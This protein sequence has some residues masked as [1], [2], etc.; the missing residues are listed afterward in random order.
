MQNM[1]TIRPTQAH[2]AKRLFELVREFPTPTPPNQE[3]F[4]ACFH[5]KLTDSASYLALAEKEEL[6]VGYISGQCHLA[7]YAGGKTAWVDEV[8]V[9]SRFRGQ[10]IGRMLVEALERW[11]RQQNCVLV[12]LATA[13]SRGFYELLGYTSKAGYYKKYLA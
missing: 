1:V 6:L 5:S 2:D 13:G 9:T 11:A 4:S 12:S 8:L 3:A 7:F 10:G